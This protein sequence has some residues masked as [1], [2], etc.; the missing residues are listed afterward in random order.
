MFEL[1]SNAHFRKHIRYLAPPDIVPD[2]FDNVEAVSQQQ[3]QPVPDIALAKLISEWANLATQSPRWR[4]GSEDRCSLC[5]L[6]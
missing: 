2:H 5:S 3:Q 1:H 4:A 6:D